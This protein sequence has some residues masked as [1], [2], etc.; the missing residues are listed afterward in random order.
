MKLAKKIFGAVISGLIVMSS[1]ISSYAIEIPS[2]N[3][4]IGSEENYKKFLDIMVD[5]FILFFRDFN[6]NLNGGIVLR[7]YP[8]YEEETLRLRWCICSHLKLL[9]IS[10]GSK[11]FNDFNVELKEILSPMIRIVDCYREIHNKLIDSC[12]E[13]NDI[14]LK[15][16]EEINKREQLCREHLYDIVNI[17]NY[18]KSN[19]K[20][21]REYMTTSDSE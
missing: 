15:K 10:L 14:L 19:E 8:N 18:V 7:L 4:N 1:G 3:W 13:K 21:L 9:A 2:I 17:I 5:N 16:V 6:Y 20:N 12:L 11:N